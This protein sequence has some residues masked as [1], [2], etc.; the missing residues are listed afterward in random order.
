MS[1]STLTPSPAAWE[2]RAPARSAARQIPLL[3]AVAVTGTLAAAV[4]WT[5]TGKTVDLVVDGKVRAV[6]F[7]GD[8]VADLLQGAGLAAGEHDVLVPA[9]S[10]VLE[11][12]A[13]VALR[14][15]RQVELVVDG[16][17]RT[18]WVTAASVD[19]ALAQVG[20]RE[21][22]MGLS[23]SRSRQLPLDGF[24]LAVT[25]PKRIA[26][27]ADNATRERDTGTATVA[28]A[29]A[30][31]GIVLDADD[32]ISYPAAEPIAEGLIIRVTRIGVETLE[33]EVSVPFETVEKS[34]ATLAR[35][36][37]KELVAGV[38]G[39]LRRTVER[40]LADGVVEK[41]TVLS[42]TPIAA[43]VNRVV[44]VG[45]NAPET[46][47][48]ASS[49]APAAA[50]DAASSTPRGGTAGA[51]DLNWAALARCE[52]GGNP[53]ALSSGGRYRGLYQFSITTWR[54]IGGSGDPIEAS[55]EE[56]TY[57]AKLLY[58]RSG[59]GQWPNC[60]RRLFS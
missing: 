34:D 11:D 26:I 35:G 50:T 18:V 10:T 32:R 40:V 39:T 51:D 46:R 6:D 57:R 5:A 16:A 12:G 14:R 29:L 60:G 2:R 59:A 13:T 23:A 3:L 44:A 38:N 36:S 49:T 30:E 41:T 21:Q 53:R 7:R 42:S 24:R 58:L 43:P 4:A 9:A 45:T 31:S 17:P 47:N 22:N 25:T 55:A 37:T 27:I 15:G 33:E 20:L 48:A 28:E 8:T 1:R 52:S 19:E 54:G 56:Q